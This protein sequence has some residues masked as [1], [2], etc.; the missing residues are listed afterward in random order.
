MDP[1]DV[2]AP[3]MSTRAKIKKALNDYSIYIIM[4]L[5]TAIVVFIP[6]LVA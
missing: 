1:R 6:P 2:L 3:D 5:V 4:V